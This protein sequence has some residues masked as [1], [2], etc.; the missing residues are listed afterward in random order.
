MARRRSR[1]TRPDV[2]AR[3]ARL[4]ELRKL[5]GRRPVTEFIAALRDPAL[6]VAKTAAMG[7]CD[8]QAVIQPLSEL[9]ADPDP[10]L[11]WRACSLA[12]FFMIKDFLP[13]L[14]GALSDPDPMVRTEAAWAMRSAET[15][16]AAAALLKALKDPQ[17]MVAHYASWTLRRIIRPRHPHLP[18]LR[19]ARIPELPLLPEPRRRPARRA[20]G[21]GD[22]ALA[23]EQ[24]AC[25]A[26]LPAY[27][28]P[29]AR[30]QRGRQAADPPKT[31]GRRDR[32]YA[33]AAHAELIHID[34]YPQPPLRK[35]DFRVVC[36]AQALHF[37]I[38]CA[39]RR[40]GELAARHAAYG[41]PVYM[42]NSLEIFLEPT[43]RGRAPYFQICLNTRNARCDVLAWSPGHT[44]KPA[45]PRDKEPWRPKHIQTA[46]RVEKGFWNAE[47]TV[48]FA[49][50]GLKPGRINKVWRMNIIR[51]AHL[52][53]CGEQTSW[54]DLGD[55]D[56]HQPAKFGYLWVDA[57]RIVNAD[58]DI[59][60]ATPLPLAR[61]L[62]GWTLLKGDVRPP[63]S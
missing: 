50:L 3:V 59:F 8:R 57:G 60:S 35:T 52:P 40:R 7:L 11:R 58:A 23:F 41:S 53:E 47:L 6:P 54:C 46:V 12:W 24:F 30:P 28:A 31:D 1:P 44:W 38:R 34:G 33:R 9:L 18:S 43:G 48:P 32:A 22:D 62:K 37:H 13:Q 2:E 51:N 42:D 25:S 36:T 61:G 29:Q 55:H 10:A 20:R 63:R 15:D 49:E 45:G 14:I 5:K 56:A 27:R 39:Y 21:V 4:A 16:A 19:R 26:E 17:R